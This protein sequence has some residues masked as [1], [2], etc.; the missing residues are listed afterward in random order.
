MTVMPGISST[1]FSTW[2]AILLSR[3]EVASSSTHNFLWC[4]KDSCDGDSLLFPARKDLIHPLST[5]FPAP[6]PA[7]VQLHPDQPF[8]RGVHIYLFL[9]I[10][11]K[12]CDII[13]QSIFK[14]IY[15]LRNDCYLLHHRLFGYCMHIHIIKSYL[16]LIIIVTTP[17][18]ASSALTFR[19]HSP[20]PLSYRFLF[21]KGNIYI[22]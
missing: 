4:K 13:S 3:L 19:F 8:L 2:Y 14:Y 12:Q 7:F 11:I 15:I 1:A 20:D 10:R 5:R 22:I 21:S 16:S 17:I 18:P 9:C 6:F